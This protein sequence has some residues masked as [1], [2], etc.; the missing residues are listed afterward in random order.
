MIDTTKPPRLVR[1]YADKWGVAWE[2]L[3]SDSVAAA[4]DR[5]REAL[6]SGEL[7]YAVDDVREHLEGFDLGCPCGSDD[8]HADVLLEIANGQGKRD[9]R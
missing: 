2:S 8:C 4:V 3:V 7:D 9:D 6:L 5:Y 1:H